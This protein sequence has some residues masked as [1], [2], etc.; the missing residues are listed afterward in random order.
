MAAS[1]ANALYASVLLLQRVILRLGE[2]TSVSVEMIEGLFASDFAYLQAKYLQLND[3][4]ETVVETQCP[5]CGAHLAVD[6][7]PDTTNIHG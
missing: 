5:A 4:G 6:L 1:G 7:L 3:G 2:L